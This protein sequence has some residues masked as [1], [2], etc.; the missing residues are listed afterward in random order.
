MDVEQRRKL[1]TLYAV[2]FMNAVGGWA[3]VVEEAQ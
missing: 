3:R 2:N 1:W